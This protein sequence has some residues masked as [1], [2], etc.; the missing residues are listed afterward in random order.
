MA[1]KLISS[2][3]SFEKTAGYSRAV[4]DGDWVF[5]SGTTGFDY[6]KMAIAE[7]VVEQLHQTFRNISAAL[8]Q[9]GC[10]LKDVVRAHYILPNA[11]DWPQVMPLLGRYFGDIRPASTAIIAGLVD[12]RMK[13]EIEVTA[14]LPGRPRV[15]AAAQRRRAARP[16]A[17]KKAGRRATRKGKR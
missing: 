3:S 15:S 11:A 5:M 2:G 16:K 14:R 7:D 4:V 17:K 12:P 10:S 9:A 13:I 6:A 8:A 1:R